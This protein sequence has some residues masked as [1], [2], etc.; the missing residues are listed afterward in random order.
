MKKII[1]NVTILLLSYYLYYL[2]K[3]FSLFT[4]IQGIYLDTQ[5]LVHC[6][7]N[8]YESNF[9]IKKYHFDYDESIK[10]F[11]DQYKFNNCIVLNASNIYYAIY[12]DI[13]Y[14]CETPH[15]IGSIANK[16][17]NFYVYY[18][19][20][21][22]SDKCYNFQQYESITKIINLIK[23]TINKL[24]FIILKILPIKIFCDIIFKILKLK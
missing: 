1:Q 4:K 2:S 14:K 10:M 13:L 23:K 12:D 5:L 16:Y 20:N 17:E 15:N 22:F 18:Y 3:D 19:K 7:I 24:C 6:N 8:L 21:I 9:I 11:M